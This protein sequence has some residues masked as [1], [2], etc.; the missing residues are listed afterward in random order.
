MRETRSVGELLGLRAVVT[1]ACYQAIMKVNGQSMMD[2]EVN[3]N[4]LL[5]LAPVGS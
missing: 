5:T 1:A 4:V 3:N 2:I